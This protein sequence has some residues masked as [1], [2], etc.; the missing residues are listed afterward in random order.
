MPRGTKKDNLR[1]CEN[2]YVSEQKDQNS[3]L[4][5]KVVKAY[6][7][8]GWLN[9]IKVMHRLLKLLEVIDKKLKISALSMVEKVNKL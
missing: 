9:Q 2:L 6:L 7:N 5:V 8:Y 3:A 1:I 4:K